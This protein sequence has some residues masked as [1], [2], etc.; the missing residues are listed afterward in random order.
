MINRRD[1]LKLLSA[2]GLLAVSGRAWGAQRSAGIR[3]GSYMVSLEE[4]KLAGLEGAE[5]RS[6]SRPADRL[7]IADPAV[8]EQYKQAMRQTGL[9]IPSV[10]VGV[11]N[12]CPLASD[13]RGPAWLEQ[14]IDGAQD[15]GAKVILVAFFS[16]GNLLDESKRVKQADVDVVVE[17]LKAAAPRAEKAGVVLALENLL[18]ARQNLEIL[19]RIG[20]KSVRIYYDVG[21]T[22]GQGYDV[23]AEI[24]LLGDR[25]V[26]FHF[27]DNPHYLGE[28]QIQF[29]PIAA[30]IRDLGYRGWIV[31]ENVSPSKDKVADAR[32]NGAFVKKLFGLAE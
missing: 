14:A 11:F 15:L 13:P 3:V 8:R 12:T 20:H 30:A 23:P 29:A 2:G 21:N 19:E 22:F 18:S 1:A 5:I 31:L 24:R 26:Q 4:A 9:P 28:G 25:I 32:R 7:E 10:T 6:G 27:K 16:K 17:R